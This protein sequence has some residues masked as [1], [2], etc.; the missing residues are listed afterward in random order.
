MTQHKMTAV[1]T[2]HEQ[3]LAGH[4]WTLRSLPAIV[5]AESLLVFQA[6]GPLEV[7][8][9]ILS[10]QGPARNPVASCLQVPAVVTAESVL[11]T[12]LP[13]ERPPF[14]RRPAIILMA[15]CRCTTFYPLREMNAL[16]MGR[17]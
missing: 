2:F 6:V 13:L 15:T 11:L 14:N 12:Q 1:S 7:S 3:K 9:K 8:N 16:F 4:R 5:E 10:K 17:W